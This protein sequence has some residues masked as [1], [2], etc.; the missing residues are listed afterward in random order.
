MPV[1]PL[2][3]LFGRQAD[4]ALAAQAPLAGYLGLGSKRLRRLTG[5][6]R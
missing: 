2:D 4:V 3:L 5:G 1:A 6:R